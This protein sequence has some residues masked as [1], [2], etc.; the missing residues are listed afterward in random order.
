MVPNR[1]LEFPSRKLQ[2]LPAGA[3][4]FGSN[5]LQ[6]CQLELLSLAQMYCKVASWSCGLWLKCTAKLP[7]ALSAVLGYCKVASCCGL[8]LK[9]TSVISRTWVLQSWKSSS[10]LTAAGLPRLVSLPAALPLPWGAGR[11]SFRKISRPSGRRPRP[12][13]P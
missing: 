8:W 10:C 2:K 6:S 3:A 7:V 1:A 9:C 11:A 12:L 13:W 4:V 5:V